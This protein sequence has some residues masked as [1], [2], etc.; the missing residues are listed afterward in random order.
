MEL[1][2]S[3]L[4]RKQMS[5]IA[6]GSKPGLPPLNTVALGTWCP[7]QEPKGQVKATAVTL[8]KRQAAEGRDCLAP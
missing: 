5:V 3:G 2:S 7:M 8:G 6:G 4:S 1:L